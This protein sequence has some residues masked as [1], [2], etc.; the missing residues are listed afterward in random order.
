MNCPTTSFL[1]LDNTLLGSVTTLASSEGRCEGRL[2]PAPDYPAARVHLHT[3][4]RG[5]A[6]L[7]G[8]P[9]SQIKDA[10]HTGHRALKERGLELRDA[11]GNVIPTNIILV[12]DHYPLNCDTRLLGNALQIPVVFGVAELT[13][14]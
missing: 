5:L 8:M 4:T 14:T 9:P 2:D 7:A 10:I 12:G 3:L 11:A 6:G 13:M 1:F